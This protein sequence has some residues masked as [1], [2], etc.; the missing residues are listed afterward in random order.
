M[1]ACEK[2]LIQ[3]AFAWAGNTIYHLSRITLLE[4]S[5]HDGFR[6][7]LSTLI[8]NLI[9]C[10]K[11]NTKNMRSTYTPFWPICQAAFWRF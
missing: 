3:R 6:S 11:E 1:A 8:Q 7:P 4:H 10:Y 5:N 2:K 9:I